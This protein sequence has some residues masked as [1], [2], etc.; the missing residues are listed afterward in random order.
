MMVTTIMV[1]D[2]LI[3][4]MTV[5]GLQIT[6]MTTQSMTVSD[7]LITICHVPGSPNQN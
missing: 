5:Y 4:T 2:L 1:L 7:I 6:I 3:T